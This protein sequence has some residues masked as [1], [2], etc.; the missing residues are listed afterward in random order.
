M[1]EDSRF[2][3]VRDEDA[4]DVIFSATVSRTRKGFSVGRDELLQAV[5]LLGRGGRRADPGRVEVDVGAH[6]DDRSG[7]LRVVDGDHAVRLLN[8]VGV[9]G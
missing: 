5:V 1:V 3:G 2:Y 9:G 4:G 7:D 8:A 6:Q